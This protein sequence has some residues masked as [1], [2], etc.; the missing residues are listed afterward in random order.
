MA[1]YFFDFYDGQ[2]AARDDLG[3]ECADRQAL[4]TEALKAL[5]QIAEDRP[6]RYVGQGLRVTVRDSHERT[7]L[8]ASLNLTAAWHADEEQSQAA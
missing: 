4:S 6:D 1:Q 3:T 2:L 5:C 7:V 8:T